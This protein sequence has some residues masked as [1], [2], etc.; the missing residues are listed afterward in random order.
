MGDG[1]WAATAVLL[2][3][4][5]FFDSGI[6]LSDFACLL[7]FWLA[8]RLSPE[9]VVFRDKNSRLYLDKQ[10][11][12]RLTLETRTVVRSMKVQAWAL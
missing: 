7:A 6:M 8:C 1:R 11:E 2:S 5:A 10:E 3:V 12:T 9:R 4:D